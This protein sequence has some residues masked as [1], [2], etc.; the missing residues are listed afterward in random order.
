MYRVASFIMKIN[1]KWGKRT[2]FKVNK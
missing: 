1:R 2:S